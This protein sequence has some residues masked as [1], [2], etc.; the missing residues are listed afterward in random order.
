MG[1]RRIDRR[2]GQYTRKQAYAVNGTSGDAS[3]HDY[4]GDSR[5]TVVAALFVRAGR[6]LRGRPDSPNLKLTH[7]PITS[8]PTLMPE[9]AIAMTLLLIAAPVVLVGGTMWMGLKKRLCDPG[10]EKL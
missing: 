3:Y 4:S 7:R 8:A 10:R 5:V 1:G 6:S 9:F 2:I